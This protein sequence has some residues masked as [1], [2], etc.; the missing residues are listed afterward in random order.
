M[1]PLTVRAEST[2]LI[3]VDVQERLLAAMPERDARRMLACIELL[4]ETARV[5]RIPV[6][7]TEQYPKGLGPTVPSVLSALGR[8]EAR[9][10]ALEKTVFSATGPVEVPRG[11][12][13]AG[14]RS[15]IAVGME[16][17]VCLF[18]TARDLRAGGYYVHVPFDAVASRDQDCKRT[19]LDLLARNG[20]SVTT[21]ETLVFDLLQD[22]S[23]P[24]FRELSK[25]VKDLP[26]GQ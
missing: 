24:N 22:A 7:L 8:H 3:I 9:P 13:S 25:R 16:A 2:A 6:F 11:L 15:V 19:A 20:V 10:A 21:T 1:D 17:H 26:L 4:A 23:H 5:L 14:V 18:Q 12:A